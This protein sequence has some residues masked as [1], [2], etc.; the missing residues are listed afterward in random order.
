MSTT[1]EDLLS[2]PF[3][4]YQRHKLIQE[5][6]AR[7][8]PNP[9][10]T[11]LD[12]GGWRGT[13]GRFL[14]EARVF[15]ADLAG[16]VPDLV[17]ADGAA[18]PFADARFDVVVSSD[19]LEHV[20]PARRAQFLRELARVSRDAVIVGAPFNSPEV[21]A[22]EAVLRA[23][24]REK[25]P[26]SFDY[27]EEHDRHGLPDLD[28]TLG[29]LY[30]AGYATVTLPNG[31]LSHWLPMLTLYFMLQ[32]RSPYEPLFNG[33]N[34]FYNAQ[35]YREN[36][37]AP[38][39]RTIVVAA[40]SGEDRLTALRTELCRGAD[41]G[42]SPDTVDWPQL[43]TLLKAIELEALTA[44]REPM[45]RILELEGLV[46]ERTRW[47]RNLGAELDR[48]RGVVGGLQ[49]DLAETSGWARRLE[50]D[51][52]AERTARAEREAALEAQ[53]AATRAWAESLNRALQERSRNI[54]VRSA[55]R[56]LRPVRALAIRPARP[57]EHDFA[58]TL[59]VASSDDDYNQAVVRS[60]SERFRPRQLVALLHPRSGFVVQERPLTGADQALVYGYHP[61][62]PRQAVAA[63]R[64]VHW[65][66]RQ[67]FDLTVI[68]AREKQY[69]ESTAMNLVGLLARPRAVNLYDDRFDSFFLDL[70]HAPELRRFV[71]RR[72]RPRTA[73]LRNVTVP[74]R[75][76]RVL[77][78]AAWWEGRRAIAG[79]HTSA[80]SG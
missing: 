9:A 39:Y 12:V 7:L 19:T 51:L 18:L 62:W 72:W 33:F 37:R 71:R 3:E 69:E 14:P 45:R 26:A 29:V 60:V 53:L 61:F 73:F 49:H 41:D 28:Q 64:L 50:A 76:G 4:Q 35:H 21:R 68:A 54:V 77:L 38:S 65:L 27:I 55:A 47:A 44:P 46:E 17:R 42:P 8:G 2:L 13:L 52:Q 75:V 23:F 40:R 31:Y 36:N 78:R 30:R 63:L 43:S 70:A 24:I 32:W 80:I 57:G 34:A 1:A 48:A 25:Y 58:K 59:V 67:E 16:N 56:L 10:P 79:G 5:V 66:R 11:I 6:I 15:I 74:V 22:A 20:A